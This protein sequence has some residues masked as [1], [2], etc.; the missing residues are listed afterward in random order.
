MQ[1]YLCSSTFCDFPTTEIQQSGNQT[2][3]YSAWEAQE[4]AASSNSQAR[5][6]TA[7]GESQQVCSG[8]WTKL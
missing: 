3:G 6:R 7:L 8:Y 4:T 1:A 5:Q 2:T